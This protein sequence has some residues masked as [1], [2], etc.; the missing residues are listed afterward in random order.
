MPSTLTT[1]RALL[2]LA[3]AL[4]AAGPA[5]AQAPFPNKPVKIIVGFPAGGPL[6]AHARLLADRL[7]QLLG[8][9]LGFE[10]FNQRQC[11]AA[12]DRIVDILRRRSSQLC[13]RFIIEP[14]DDKADHVS[15]FIEECTTRIAR[16]HLHR[17]LELPWI[18]PHA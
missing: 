8:Q 15:V 16:L 7:G 18:I 10:A 11:I 6:D 2:A 5:A 9:Q 17:Y 3:A 4:A 14:R 1:R 13:C 12:L